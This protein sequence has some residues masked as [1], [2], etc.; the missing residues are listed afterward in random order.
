MRLVSVAESRIKLVGSNSG[1]L[2]EL[3]LSA[4]HGQAASA[5]LSPTS[6]LCSTDRCQ[7]SRSERQSVTWAPPAR[8]DGCQTEELSQLSIGFPDPKPSQEDC[9][10]L[11]NLDSALASNKGTYLLA[12]FF[13]EVGQWCSSSLWNHRIG[14]SYSWQLLVVRNF[15]KD[16]RFY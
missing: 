4:Q 16:V 13:N 5:P 12:L 8:A 2:L 6:A 7:T 14:V 1:W 15:V 3:L 9:P 11:Q 10:K